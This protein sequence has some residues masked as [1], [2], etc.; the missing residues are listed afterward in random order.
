MLLVSNGK[1]IGYYINF[2]NRTTGNLKKKILSVVLYVGFQLKHVDGR[3]TEWRMAH[4][5]PNAQKERYFFMLRIAL[6]ISRYDY[7]MNLWPT[8]VST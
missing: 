7:L 8:S 5:C 1:K 3:R 2:K 6:G 4:F